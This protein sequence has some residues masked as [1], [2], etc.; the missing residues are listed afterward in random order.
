MR[1]HIREIAT[2]EYPLDAVRVALLTPDPDADPLA[3]V[4]LAQDLATAYRGDPY[5]QYLLGLALYRAGEF[6]QVDAKLQEALTISPDWEVRRMVFPIR[7]MTYHRLGH[8]ADARKALA[9][10][11]RVIDDWTSQ[12]CRTNNVN[13][14]IHQGVGNWPVYWWDWL[15]CQLF[16][17]EASLLID[18]SS[19]LEDPRLHLIRARG[20]AGLRRAE[21]A[22]DEYDAA[23][24][25]LPNDLQIQFER[26]RT[27]GY[28]FGYR[29]WARSA[30]EFSAARRLM[31]DQAAIWNLEAISQLAAGNRKAYR[32]LCQEML[33]RFSTTQDPFTAMN[34]VFACVLE[35]D[36]VSHPEQL[37]PLAQVAGR[38]S[39]GNSRILGATFCRAGAD[40]DAVRQLDDS[41]RLLQPKSW[42]L[43]FLALAH[44]HLGHTAEAKRC[45]EAAAR[46]MADANQ[47]ATV[48]FQY[49]QQVWGGFTERFEFPRLYVE[50]AALIGVPNAK[51]APDD[52]SGHLKGPAADGSGF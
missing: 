20:F 4:E 5:L 24:K 38:L 1:T 9:E 43:C 39:R 44:K 11:A 23:I 15:E 21:N 32:Q 31:P 6:E 47:P 45:L 36:A 33:D 25:G 48:T 41:A 49:N 16:Y 28:H 13:W 12:I 27:L 26:S 17:R 3:L 51:P 37:I 34:V 29:D 46:W 18:G 40:E 50:A 14:A 30:R 8:A 35:P 52:A 2:R 10:A 42:E 7:A 22:I 19:P